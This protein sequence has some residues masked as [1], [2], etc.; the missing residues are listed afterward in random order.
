MELEFLY[1]AEISIPVIQI[2]AL[3]VLS[4]L[5]LFFGKVK[6]AL[7]INYIFA[8]YWGFF[9]NRDLLKE[10][11]AESQ[12][13]MMVYFGLGIAVVIL[14]ALGFLAHHKK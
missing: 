1:M 10:M 3:L 14:A 7:M 8:L 2:V 11:A 5:V 12:T 6:I 4:T 9:L 13:L